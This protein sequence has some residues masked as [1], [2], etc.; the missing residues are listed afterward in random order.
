MSPKTALPTTPKPDVKISWRMRLRALRNVVP[1]LRLHWES[2]PSLVL[3]TAFLRLCRSLLPVAGLCI[4][5]LI[6]DAL[7]ARVMHQ[8]GDV[9]RIWNLVALQLLFAIGMD[10]LARAQNLVDS[11][12]ADRFGKNI[13]LRIMEHA[14][15]LDLACFED[16]E[17]TDKLQR[18]R[19]QSTRRLDMLTSLLDICQDSISLASL[20]LGLIVFSPWLMVLLVV[21]VIPAFLGEVHFSRLGY[22]IMYRRTPERRF[23][24]YLLML[25]TSPQSTKEI[26]I[27]GLGGFLCR[28]YEDISDAA[29]TENRAVAK[30]KAIVGSLLGLIST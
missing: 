7:V 16:H 26:K 24:E 10:F 1:I 19:G 9:M 30:K 4:T 18:A 21:A 23:L 3:A 13:N 22:S 27:F 17:F 29:I 6:M 11:M 25:T 2:S 15:R 8:S 5:K 20:S 28:R 14:T 12:L